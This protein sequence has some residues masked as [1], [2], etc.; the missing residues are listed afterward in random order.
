LELVP[1]LGDEFTLKQ[2]KAVSLR[3]KLDDKGSVVALELFQPGGVFE[4]KRTEK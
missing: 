1:G 3:F 4:A 2:I